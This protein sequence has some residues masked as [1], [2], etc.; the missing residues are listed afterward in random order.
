MKGCN[1]SSHIWLRVGL[2]DS[3]YSG[4]RRQKCPVASFTNTLLCMVPLQS[5]PQD[6]SISLYMKKSAVS[7]Q[8]LQDCLRYNNNHKIIFP[9]L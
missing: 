3:I 2:V 5:Y 8:I 7:T 1:C 4:D 6:G 9:P